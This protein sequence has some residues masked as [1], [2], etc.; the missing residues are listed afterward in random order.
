MAD[1][2]RTIVRTFVSERDRNGN[3]YKF[4]MIYAVSAG[5]HKIVTVEDFSTSIF[6]DLGIRWG[7]YLEIESCIPK[8]E[9][10]AKRK[11]L[12]TH[13]AH[14]PEYKAAMLELF[15]VRC[16]RCRKTAD[17]RHTLVDDKGS[18]HHHCGRDHAQVT[19][20]KLLEESVAQTARKISE[21][22]P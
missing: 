22:A 12:S 3:C 14:T 11:S 6:P 8:R 2:I 4:S 1:P 5:I 20:G 15:G 18:A 13:Y 21:C 19:E 16:S 7:E 9:W 10:Q 17:P